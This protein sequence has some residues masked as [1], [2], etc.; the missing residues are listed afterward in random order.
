MTMK[1]LITGAN[2]TNKGAQSMLFVTVDEVRKRF[3]DA[4][5]LFQT[6]ES[7]DFS[8]YRFEPVNIIWGLMGKG[9]RYVTR[10]ILRIAKD[11]V[12]V[13]LGQKSQFLSSLKAIKKIEGLDLIIDISGF[14]IGEKWS[15]GYNQNYIYKLEYARNNSIPFYIMPQSIGPFGFERE[16]DVL[17]AERLRRS[18]SDLLRYP[19]IIF[20]REKD[21]AKCLADIGISENVVISTDLVLQNRGICYKNIFKEEPELNLINIKTSQN[22]ALV[23]N[24]QCV[25][26]GAEKVTLDIYRET[27][28]HMLDI[29]KEVYIICHS[30][31]D[32]EI[33]EM[34]FNSIESEHLH[35]IK[36]N[37]SCLEYD[38]LI[39][40]FEYVVG[41][42]FHGLV[43]ALRN[44]VPCIALG[45]AIKYKELMESV[46][47]G[48]YVF[49]ITED[50]SK[51]SILDAVDDMNE[52]IESNK[53][54]VGTKLEAI[55]KDN[56][57]LFLDRFTIK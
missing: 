36:Q 24:K 40:Q 3:P 1:I 21:A 41:S 16:V 50:F 15:K 51:W 42:R 7:L 8:N 55:Q 17:E 18:F 9:P 34:L 46:D 54:K 23:P 33:C 38:H 13:V 19:T 52:N 12:K 37:L 6:F 26:H 5:I 25:K 53:R 27:I 48:E 57:F 28:L 22:V 2:F 32:G 39:K 29:G 10:R 11:C 35:L 45:W 20:A 44:D 47:Q 31:E 43:H 30:N 14:A 56:C 49:N 4:E